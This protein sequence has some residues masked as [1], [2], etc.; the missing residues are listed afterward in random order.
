MPG[1]VK[2]A[3]LPIVPA[4]SEEEITEEQRAEYAEINSRFASGE[5]EGAEEEEAPASSHDAYAWLYGDLFG[6]GDDE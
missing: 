3:R 6:E 2:D 5:I 1:A 4:V